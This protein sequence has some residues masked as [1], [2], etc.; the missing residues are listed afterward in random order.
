MRLASLIAVTLATIVYGNDQ[1]PWRNSAGVQFA[2]KSKSNYQRVKTDFIKPP[3]DGVNKIMATPE[4]TIVVL[5]ERNTILATH[6]LPGRILTCWINDGSQI[7][8][9][10]L[11]AISFPS[12]SNATKKMINLDGLENLVWFL[13][14]GES[15]I[16]CVSPG[17]GK[18]AY[19]KLPEGR[20]ISITF[21]DQGLLIEAGGLNWELSWKTFDPIRQNLFTPRS[22]TQKGTALRPFLN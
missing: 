21:A 13:D 5:N 9:K 2:S 7:A 1:L 22:K 16:T 6:H 14:D 20:N 8:L 18:I 19:L 12:S 15:F 10:T 4:G 11:S 17:T 3:Q